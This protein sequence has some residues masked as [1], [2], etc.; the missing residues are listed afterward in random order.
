M[1]VTWLQWECSC[2]FVSPQYVNNPHC[3]KMYISLRNLRAVF[4]AVQV[5]GTMYRS[6]HGTLQA[7]GVLERTQ[8]S[9]YFLGV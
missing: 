4:V 9:S 6:I 1:S 7:Y 3:M 8:V 5:F 2:A